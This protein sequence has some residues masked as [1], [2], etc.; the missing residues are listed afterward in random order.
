MFTCKKSKAVK[1]FQ[2]NTTYSEVLSIIYP[3]PGEV[4]FTWDFIDMS[5]T[6]GTLLVA[7][8]KFLPKDF[9]RNIM[10]GDYF[11]WTSLYALRL[12]NQ[13]QDKLN[14]DRPLEWVLKEIKLKTSHNNFRELSID[15]LVRILQYYDINP[16][17]QAKIVNEFLLEKHPEIVDFTSDSNFRCENACSYFGSNLLNEQTIVPPTGFEIDKECSTHERVVFKKKQVKCWCDLNEVSGYCFD[18]CG[19]IKATKDSLLTKN[20]LNKNVA[21][22]LK[23]AKMML[24]AAQ[25]SQLMPYYDV[26]TDSEW[27]SLYFNCYMPVYD[28]DENKISVRCFD[29]NVAQRLL[30][31]HTK[32][33]AEEFIRNNEQLI[34]DYLMV[35]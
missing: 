3:H 18:I 24:A 20:L 21:A 15:I 27:K 17:S 19:L 25:I 22:N 2:K 34:K 28:L 6:N 26:F 13:I 11:D 10:S 4:L 35:D 5:Q 32:E 1:I 30:V 7:G 16:A 14:P 33:K 29:N 12:H 9:V 31:F 23:T 8:A